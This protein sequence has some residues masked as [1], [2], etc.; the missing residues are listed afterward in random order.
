VTD[1]EVGQFCGEALAVADLAA[2]YGFAD[3]AFGDSS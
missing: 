1:P 3:E 2:E